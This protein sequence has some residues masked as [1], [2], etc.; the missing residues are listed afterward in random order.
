MSK[1]LTELVKEKEKNIKGLPF[2]FQQIGDSAN[3]LI[4]NYLVEMSKVIELREKFRKIAENMREFYQ[5]LARTELLEL[6]GFPFDFQANLFTKFLSSIDDFLGKI[7]GEYKITWKFNLFLQDIRFIN[8]KYWYGD[9]KRAEIESKLTNFATLQDK[10]RKE[11]EKYIISYG[12]LTNLLRECFDSPRGQLKPFLT[13]QHEEENKAKVEAI[14][15]VEQAKETYQEIIQYLHDLCQLAKDEIELVN[16]SLR[17]AKKILGKDINI[18]DQLTKPKK[19]FVKDNSSREEI[20]EFTMIILK[21]I[22]EIVEN[23]VKGLDIT[24]CDNSEE[25][26]EK[27]RQNKI[28]SLEK[29]L[30]RVNKE[31]SEHEKK[32]SELVTELGENKNNLNSLEKNIAKKDSDFQEITDKKNELCDKLSKVLEE[33]KFES[34]KLTSE[35]EKLNSQNDEIATLKNQIDQLEIDLISL[36]NE[37]ISFQSEKSALNSQLSSLQQAKETLTNELSD[38]KKIHEE[39]TLESRKNREEKERLEVDYNWLQAQLDISI[40]DYNEL[41]LQTNDLKV[42]LENIPFNWKEQIDDWK[43]KY[44]H[45]NKNLQQTEQERDNYKFKLGGQEKEILQKFITQLKLKLESEE[46]TTT[47]VIKEIKKLI[48]K[49]PNQDSS[50]E[51]DAPKDQKE[52]ESQIANLNKTLDDFILQKDKLKDEVTKIDKEK[53]CLINQNNQLQTQLNQ[54]EQE[55]LISLLLGT[56]LGIIIT[57]ITISFILKR[58]R[59]NSFPNKSIIKLTL[60]IS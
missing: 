35:Q 8:D 1:L 41:L 30:L 49:V 21:E 47:E 56:E 24:S 29:E 32:I 25:N 39:L 38:I 22:E 12:V 57:I 40:E 5:Y 46:I 36:Q 59:R 44:S 53:H 14:T 13:F 2:Y 17:N 31:K 34:E 42:K 58:K 16:K 45:E 23:R 27:D 51:T 7:D 9:L 48:I 55:K 15:N 3:E 50:E 10:E 37:K 26:E 6:S 43:D 52:R 18:T 28:E 11:I 54:K 4:S 19:D 20:K 60:F 33:L